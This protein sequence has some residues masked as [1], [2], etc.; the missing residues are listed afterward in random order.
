MHQI[1]NLAAAPICL[2]TP[3][4][5]RYKVKVSNWM[6]SR[7][8]IVFFL[9]SALDGAGD[10]KRRPLDSQEKVSVT[11]RTGDWMYLMVN[12]NAADS[13]K[14]NDI[15]QLSSQQR[16]KFNNLAVAKN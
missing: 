5:L 3:C 16:R 2:G 11:H 13:I 14:M 10:N 12:V 4:T 6:C 1:I 8:I 9:Q 7:R 15:F